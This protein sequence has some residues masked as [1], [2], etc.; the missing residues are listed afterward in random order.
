MMIANG[1]KFMITSMKDFP[2][3]EVANDWKLSACGDIDISPQQQ[4]FVFSKRRDVAKAGDC[5]LYVS[6]PIL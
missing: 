5:V 3:L 6:K 4:G 2:T 1:N